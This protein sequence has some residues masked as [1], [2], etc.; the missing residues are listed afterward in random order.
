M[1]AETTLGIG[2]S[3]KGGRSVCESPLLPI[4]YLSC[5]LFPLSSL[6]TLSIWSG[7]HRN[8][9]ADKGDGDEKREGID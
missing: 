3:K 7:L 1:D 8:E 4:I 2:G 6:L 5:P 9:K